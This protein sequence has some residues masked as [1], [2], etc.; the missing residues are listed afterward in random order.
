MHD[1][2]LVNAYTRYHPRWFENSSRYTPTG[3]YLDVYRAVVPPDWELGEGAGFPGEQVVRESADFATGT[4]G[5]A[6]FLDR[7]LGSGTGRRD[8]FNF[9]VDELL[10]GYGT[11]RT[12]RSTGSTPRAL[13][14]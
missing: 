5:V 8:N 4:A 12:W 6:L 11:A 9:V 14:W 13:L 2:A 7:L 1:W 3:E 10:P